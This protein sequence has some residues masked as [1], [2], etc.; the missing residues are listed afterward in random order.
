MIGWGRMRKK[1]W[2]CW[3]SYQ[4]SKVDSPERQCAYS[5]SMKLFRGARGSKRK[6]GV[7]E[8]APLVGGCSLPQ[9]ELGAPLVSEGSSTEFCLSW[10]TTPIAAGYLST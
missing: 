7:R 5:P 3:Q 6:G 8:E 10:T 1:E 4:V 2:H 9:E